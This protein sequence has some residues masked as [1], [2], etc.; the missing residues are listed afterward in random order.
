MPA[1]QTMGRHLLDMLAVSE[2]QDG[3]CFLADMGFGVTISGAKQFGML[4][5]TQLDTETGNHSSPPGQ[6][7]YHCNT[8][9]L[10][11]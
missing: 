8:P 11:C 9:V 2:F 1:V 4:F 5:G 3:R 10:I 7:K 6:D